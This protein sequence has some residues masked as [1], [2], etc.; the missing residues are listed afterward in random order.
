MSPE[1]QA[2]KI[3]AEATPNP[4][5]IKFAVNRRFL[6]S[7]GVDFP[8]A[9]SAE[10]SPLSSRLFGLNTVSGVYIGTDFIS[11]TRKRDVDWATLVP[12]AADLIREVLE[13]GVTIVEEKTPDAPAAQN[14]VEKKIREV[15][16]REIR[17]AVA[18][19]GGDITFIAYKDGVVTLHLKGSCSSCPSAILTLKA[20]VESRLRATIPE[21]KE[22]EQI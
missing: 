13:S 2:L 3:S 9:A 12:R 22:V 4:N 8:D 20:G 5:T 1:V 17:P 15:L 10:K 18:M 19:D 14:S 6:S 11:V 7:G 16:D 21:V